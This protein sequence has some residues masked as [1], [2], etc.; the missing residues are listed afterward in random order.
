[1]EHVLSCHTVHANMVDL[2]QAFHTICAGTMHME[3][4]SNAA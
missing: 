3:T 1:M 4:G 2:M